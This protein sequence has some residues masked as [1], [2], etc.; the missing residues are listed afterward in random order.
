MIEAFRGSGRGRNI[1]TCKN[2]NMQTGMNRSRQ[3]IR[4]I[5]K[6]IG[7]HRQTPIDMGETDKWP[8]EPDVDWR[9]MV[10]PDNPAQSLGRPVG[11]SASTVAPDVTNV[12][13][14][15]KRMAQTGNNPI[16]LV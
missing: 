16:I 6:H 12:E 8:V 11:C 1:Q 4:Q 5:Q 14:F 9:L 2:R 10:G 3:R 15:D 7:R 13:D